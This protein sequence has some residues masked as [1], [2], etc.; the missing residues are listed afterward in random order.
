M[1][2]TIVGLPLGN[3]QDISL[4]A[5]ATLKLS[6]NIICEDTRVFGRLWQKLLQM[7]LVDSNFG[8]NYFVL[9]DFNE[10]TAA[11]DLVTKLTGL[12]VVLVS[13]AG[14]PTVSDPGYR[15]VREALA[16]GW[17]IDVVPGPT[18]AM[19]ALA[20]SGLPPDL[21]VFAGFLP[22]KTSKRL[23]KLSTLNNFADQ[24]ATV[25]LYESPYR[26]MKLLEGVLNVF[27]T[28][29]IAVCREM[30]KVHQ[31][32]TRGE[33]SNVIEQMKTQSPRGEYVVVLNK[34]SD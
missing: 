7:G 15:L 26:V 33:L 20:L 5:L 16:A 10:R 28:A 14:L 22:Q 30:T 11:K 3:A 6:Q 9:N 21:V 32:V 29:Q 19:N 4:R 31:Q 8:G 23:E 12:E 2:L 13:D 25:I 24:G 34:K 17:E 27:K 18:A 1:R